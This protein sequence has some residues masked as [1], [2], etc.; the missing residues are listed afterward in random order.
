MVEV[1]GGGRRRDYVLVLEG[2]NDKGWGCFVSQLRVMVK[3]IQ[4]I[5][6]GRFSKELMDPK[7]RVEP[8]ATAEMGG[9]RSFVEV[10]SA[11]AKEL[12]AV[13]GCGNSFLPL[14]KVPLWL[15]GSGILF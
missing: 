4:S 2:R 5:H 11:S 15:G 12:L 9:T 14:A 6:G 1:S 7:V 10:L 3:L 13:G 8:K